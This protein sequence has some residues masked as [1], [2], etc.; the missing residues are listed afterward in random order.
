VFSS[1]FTVCFIE[2]FS[3]QF[4]VR[5]S[6][7]SGHTERDRVL[8]TRQSACVGDDLIAVDEDGR[9]GYLQPA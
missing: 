9:L 3:S 1:S 8:Q 5:F 6:I 4:L 2:F 7:Q